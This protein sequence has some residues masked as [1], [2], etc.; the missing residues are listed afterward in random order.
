MCEYENGMQNVS[1]DAEAPEFE[2]SA[3]NP[4]K[5][6]EVIVSSEDLR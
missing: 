1:I 5:D 3:Y 2:I 4:M 6:S